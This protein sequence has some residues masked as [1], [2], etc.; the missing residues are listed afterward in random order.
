MSMSESQAIAMMLQTNAT[1]IKVSGEIDA[2][3]RKVLAPPLTSNLG[4]E[5]EIVQKSNQEKRR[6]VSTD[7]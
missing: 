7:N 5:I 3:L 1:L 6:N 2:L 4:F